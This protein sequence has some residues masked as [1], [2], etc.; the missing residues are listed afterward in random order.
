MLNVLY[1][2]EL[3]L[4]ACAVVQERLGVLVMGSTSMEPQEEK[5]LRSELQQG[6]SKVFQVPR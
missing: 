3:G 4:G 5:I 1:D 2:W 6:H